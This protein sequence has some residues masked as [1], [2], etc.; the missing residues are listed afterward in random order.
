M[1]DD[2]F[3]T[4]AIELSAQALTEKAASPSAPWS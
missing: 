4:R 1:Y 2:S 3:M